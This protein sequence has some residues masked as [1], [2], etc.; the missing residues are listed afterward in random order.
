MGISGIKN[1]NLNFNK[2]VGYNN[3]FNNFSTIK[4]VEYN[5]EQ[6]NYNQNNSNCDTDFMSF[7]EPNTNLDLDE[8]VNYVDRTFP[9]LSSWE[10]MKNNK[11]FQELL[12]ATGMGA[13][14]FVS[15]TDFVTKIRMESLNQQ[16]SII[17]NNL[18]D[19]NLYRENFYSD[20]SKMFGKEFKTVSDEYDN[21]CEVIQL[22]LLEA[23]DD[24][25]VSFLN[26]RNGIFVKDDDELDWKS[27]VIYECLTDGGKSKY[28]IE[29]IK[30]V[31]IGESTKFDEIYDEYSED[32]LSIALEKYNPVL[33]EAYDDLNSKYDSLIA[34]N[35]DKGLTMDDCQELLAILD[36]RINSFESQIDV[37]NNMLIKLN[38]QS[39]MNT[40][41]Y[42]KYDYFHYKDA[43]LEIVSDPER[44][45]KYLWKPEDGLSP[46]D[47]IN[48]VV[49]KSDLTIDDFLESGYIDFSIS[50]GNADYA[51]DY[52]HDDILQLKNLIAASKYDSS[53]L[54]MYNYL[55]YTKGLDAANQYIKDTEDNVNGILAQ[56]SIQSRMENMGLDKEYTVNI[57][58]KEYKATWGLN[59]NGKLVLTGL[60]DGIEQYFD[61]ILGWFNSDRAKTVDEWEQYYMMLALMSPEDK[62]KYGLVDE[63]GNSMSPYIDFSV[64]YSNGGLSS[65]VYNISSSIGNMLPSMVLSSVNPMLGSVSLGV[66]SGGNSY[67][68]AVT[69]GY[70]YGESILYAV[71]SGASE[72]LLER[73]IGSIPGL[74]KV[75]ESKVSG[76]VAW[77]KS[78]YAEGK[79]EFIQEGFDIVLRNVLFGEEVSFD[80]A[81]QQ[82]SVS[83]MYG[84]A[85]G[86]IFNVP[87]LVGSNNIDVA[88]KKVLEKNNGEL[89]SAQIAEMFEED[90]SKVEVIAEETNN[91][92]LA[93]EQMTEMFVEVDDDEDEEIP[94]VD[95]DKINTLTNSFYKLENSQDLNELKS[96]MEKINVELCVRKRN[97]DYFNQDI[98]KI[99]KESYDRK[100]NKFNFF[101]RNG[102][103]GYDV[104]YYEVI[105]KIREGDYKVIRDHKLRKEVISLLN[106]INQNEARI[107]DLTEELEIYQNDVHGIVKKHIS[108]IDSIFSGFKSESGNYGAN[109]GEIK[110]VSSVAY[111]SR[112]E[113]TELI[114]NNSWEYIAAEEYISNKYDMSKKDVSILLHGMNID[115]GTCS[116][117]AIVNEI[118]TSYIGKEA[119]FEQDFGYPMYCTNRKGETKFN[120][121]QLMADLYTFANMEENGGK[122]LRRG[123][124]DELTG[125]SLYV[126]KD[127]LSSHVDA[128][129]ELNLSSDHQQHL[130]SA[131]G[132]N[133]TLVDAFLKSHNA[134][135]SYSSKVLYSQHTDGDFELSSLTN[136]IDDEL[137]QGNHLSLGIYTLRGDIMMKNLDNGSVQVLKDAGHAVYVTNITDEGFIVSSWSSRYLLTFEEL[138]GKSFL[139][140]SSHINN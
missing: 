36:E 110:Q 17:K 9:Y 125:K 43:N 61:G 90:V 72:A 52:A 64:D 63:N 98:D 28:S 106:K 131:R 57:D 5:G 48:Y 128:I 33:R 2:F 12:S 123:Q 121:F 42:Q 92:D 104:Y 109:Q 47:Y 7:D 114:W 133:V 13:D 94:M 140:N 100:K 78:C 73:M 54:E 26:V 51:G 126:N 135:L 8:I 96:Q 137:S 25:S 76:V 46:I 80:E 71:S 82:M 21:D 19:T 75:D 11:G 45:K 86:G 120:S 99:I 34:S 32:N 85:V 4:K 74:G 55:Y 91:N 118:L 20:M 39:I 130:S 134:N 111:I 127:Y 77:L 60:G 139:I 62:V 66:S 136:A 56:V 10:E 79:E 15:Y 93:N 35:Y 14:E 50:S 107:N 132:K 41:E 44:E 113:G 30:N 84:A 129:G 68:D 1:N 122:M 103:E 37:N 59:D 108:Q 27:K 23:R 67:R 24:F 95:S 58:G 124:V 101:G 81:L 70:D 97:S 138:T 6:F 88:I 119:K 38:Y 40:S 116:Y 69:S 65:V 53:L 89:T 49:D 31:L 18:N 29:D 87:K 83:G 112:I 22:S 117:A 102:D 115:S 3:S 16:N 105:K